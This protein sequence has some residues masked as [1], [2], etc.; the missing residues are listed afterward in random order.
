MDTVK[1]IL[2]GLVQGLTEFLPVSS[3]GHLILLEKLG[4]ATPSL[5]FNVMLHLGTLL[6][7]FFVFY[8]K[9]FELI[10]HPVKSNLRY[11]ILA[12]IPTV[13]IAFLFKAYGGNLLLGDYLPLFFMIT[14]FLLITS[15]IFA[16]NKNKPL[17]FKNATL[18]GVMQGIAVLP[19]ISRSGATIA[20]MTMMGIGKEEACD[21]SFLLSI[22]I[23][24]GS[25]LV[26]CYPFKGIAVDYGA[27]PL[28]AGMIA[29]FFGGI[30]SLG[31]IYKLIKK[32][33]FLCFGIYTAIL[34][35]VLL[36]FY[37]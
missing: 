19:G 35:L 16:K 25:A 22:P 4:V 8:R 21:F 15:S 7:V 9:I 37:L 3:S 2:L 27:I 1:A 5:F 33:S 17:S 13:I 24:L 10:R 12:S 23:I 32:G 28:V 30:I 20:A 29:S 31:L 36:F 6:S 11:V 34:S 18:T 14:A 26:E